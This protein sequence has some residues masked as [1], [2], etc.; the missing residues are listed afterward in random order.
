MSVFMAMLLGLVKGLTV[1]L[2][3]SESAH[4]AI[5][6]NLFHLTVPEEGN[7]F[8]NFLLSLSTLISIIMVYR[9]ELGD[10]LHDGSDFVKGRTV[11]YGESDGRFPPT[12]RM[13]FFIFIGTL[14]F[15]LTLPLSAHSVLLKENTVFVGAALIAMGVV[16][17]VADRQIKIGK[18]SDKTM[19]SKD[20]FIIGIA[21]AL[22]VIPGL[23]RTGA[24]VTTGL[25][26][27]FKK[28][29]S[30]RFSVF[31]SLPSVVVSIIISFFAAFRGGI[32]WTSF[33]SYLLGFIVSIFSGYLAIMVLRL[34][35][36]KRKLSWF[37]YYLWVVGL[38]TI[39]LSF[40][41]SSGGS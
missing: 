6:Y 36:I 28:D 23:S 5:L 4:E 21:Q 8:F 2:P 33:F 40:T 37:S 9:R 25:A 14:P 19:R 27:G 34:L 16:L 11:E 15:L 35:T 10:L 20:A 7:G 13:I 29:F 38:A 41:L 39:I 17:F 24:T 32:L 30:V 22:S 31:L 1:F 3:V 26:L 18:L 12:I